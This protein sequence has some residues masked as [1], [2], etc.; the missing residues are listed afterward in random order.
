MTGIEKWA[1]TANTTAREIIILTASENPASYKEIFGKSLDSE[2][3][4]PTGRDTALKALLERGRAGQIKIPFTTILAHADA[5]LEIVVKAVE[6]VYDRDL[7][8]YIENANVVSTPTLPSDSLTTLL[9][10]IDRMAGRSSES[11]TAPDLPAPNASG[12]TGKPEQPD[13]PEP[14]PPTSPVG[15]PDVMTP[16]PPPPRTSPKQASQKPPAKRKT[17]YS[18]NKNTVAELL[19]PADTSF[20]V[21]EVRAF[22]LSLPDYK[23]QDMALMSDADVMDIFGKNYTAVALG[24][25]TVIMTP[26]CCAAMSDLLISGEAYCIPAAAPAKTENP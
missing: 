26:A 7:S 16:P 20:P 18:A 9:A 10:T 19:K 23:P 1:E 8:M 6:T 22:L 15:I 13:V 4:I 11:E 14:Q 5:P 12:D 21:R 3:P 24:S 17:K 25:G 2:T